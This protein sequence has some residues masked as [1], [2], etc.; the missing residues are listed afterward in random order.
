MW[1][2]HPWPFPAISAVTGPVAQLD[3]ASPS[4]G[5]GKSSL[6]GDEFEKRSKINNLIVLENVGFSTPGLR[7]HCGSKLKG[8]CRGAAAA[9][10]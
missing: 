9:K 2:F 7:K 5:R 1:P 10:R 3:R 4:E 8:G 6:P